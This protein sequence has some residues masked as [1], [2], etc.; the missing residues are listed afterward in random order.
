MN[1]RKTVLIFLMLL[2]ALPMMGQYV[3]VG[4][5]DYSGG[6]WSDPEMESFLR[7]YLVEGHG[8]GGG[9][10]AVVFE[11]HRLGMVHAV[12]VNRHVVHHRN[13]DDALFFL[14]VIHHCLCRGCHTFEKAVLVPDVFRCPK[15]AHTQQ[16]L[17]ARQLGTVG[18]RERI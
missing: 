17:G 4:T 3:V 2:L 18:K 1:F 10:D 11:F 8:V 6:D 14:E 9:Q 15:F 5:P 16:P 13:V 12:T 7:T